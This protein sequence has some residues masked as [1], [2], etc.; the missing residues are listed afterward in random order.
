MVHL[1]DLKVVS[2]LVISKGP[3]LKPLSVF[4]VDH[5]LIPGGTVDG[6]F[7]VTSRR[8]SGAAP[9]GAASVLYER[10]TR[11]NTARCLNRSPPINNSR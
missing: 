1:S 7:V 3:R 2:I 9:K 6:R 8:F 10:L 11:A 5:S 4:Q